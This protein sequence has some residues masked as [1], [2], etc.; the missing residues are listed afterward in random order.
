MDIRQCINDIEQA[1]DEAKRAVQSGPVAEPLRHCVEAMHQQASSA[2]KQ[3]GSSPDEQGQ[4]QIVT[5]LEEA[6][7]KALE[8]C[9]TSGTTVQPQL[10]QAIQRAHDEAKKLKKQMEAGST[11]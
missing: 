8:A 1:T 5:Q 3:M 7:D 9:K 2:K 11:A 4:R 10:Q 6:A